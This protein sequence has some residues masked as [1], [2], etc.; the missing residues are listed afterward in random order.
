[1]LLWFSRIVTIEA[2]DRFPFWKRGSTLKN[3]FLL[4]FSLKFFFKFPKKFLKRR[5]RRR[6]PSFSGASRPKKGDRTPPLGPK[7][8]DRDPWRPDGN[9]TPPGKQVC[10]SMIVT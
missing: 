8:G 5:L 4:H 7:T 1:M 3:H 9:R 10:A 6:N 2:H